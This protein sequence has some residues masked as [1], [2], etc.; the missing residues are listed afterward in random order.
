M[1]SALLEVGWWR[2]RAALSDFGPQ[3]FATQAWLVGPDGVG[4]L[5]YGSGVHWG[6]A[7]LGS[8]G[9]APDSA[10]TLAATEPVGTAVSGQPG[11]GT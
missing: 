4:L 2:S 9:H 8:D 10:G 7:Y 1:Y 3:D 5:V 6:T 11:H